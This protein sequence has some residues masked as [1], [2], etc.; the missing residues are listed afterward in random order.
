MP[1]LDARTLDFVSH[2]AEQTRRLGVRLGELLGGRDLLCL[3][4]DLGAGK[5]TLAAGIAVGWGALDR[6][7]SPTFVLINQYRRA[8]EAV[9]YHMDAYRL[10]SAIEAL[11]AGLADVL[12]NGGDLLLEWP[13]RILAALPD[14]RLWITL[15]WVEEEKRGLRFKAGGL[16]YEKLLAD[17]KRSAFGRQTPG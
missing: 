5:T 11:E 13:E 3:C 8:D 2:S 14:E 12:E 7:S 1:I 9:L 15:R 16:R 17:F 10:N 4:G 6:V